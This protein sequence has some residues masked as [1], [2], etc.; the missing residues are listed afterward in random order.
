MRRPASPLAIAVVATLSVVGP[1]T[2]QT[3]RAEEIAAAQAEKA[4]AMP[5]DRPGWIERTVVD[6]RRRAVESPSGPYPSID[7]IYQGGGATGGAGY[8]QYV[9]DRTYLNVR[10]LYSVKNYWGIESALISRGHRRD[11]VEFRLDAAL[12]DAPQVGYYGVGVDNDADD[13][14][15]YRLKRTIFGGQVVARP[16]RPFVLGAAVA[17]ELH[18]LDSGKGSEPSIEESYGPDEAPG[19]GRSPDY[20]HTTLTGGLDWRQA[21]GYARRG[22]GY[23]LLYHRFD[24]TGDYAFDRLDVDLVQHVPVLRETY[25]LSGHAQ[26]QSTLGDDAVPYFLLPALG[27]GRTLRGYSSFRFRD[28]HTLLLQA[29]FRWVPN[30]LGLDMA[31]FWDAGTVAPERDRLSF[32]ALRHDFGIG[33]RLHTAVATPIRVEVA[34]SE[35]GYKLV[36]AAKA[37]F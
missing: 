30:L 5:V 17:A 33:L 18:E 37:A 32:G 34:H 23:H 1:A 21:A 2:A 19:L 7:S 16:R 26:L 4:A 9:G 6:F 14:A 8:R 27:G 15:N 25:V 35:E 22:G 3:T 10:G 29:E 13:R 31:F 24:R 36:M 11:T 20:A 12:M 28:R